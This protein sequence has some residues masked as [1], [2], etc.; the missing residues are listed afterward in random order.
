MAGFSGNNDIDIDRLTHMLEENRDLINDITSKES[1][2]VGAAQIP[3]LLLDIITPMENGSE[4]ENVENS[5][6]DAEIAETSAE[7]AGPSSKVTTPQEIVHNLPKVWKVLVELLSH[8]KLKP[9]EIEVGF[10][11]C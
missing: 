3:K 6:L 5:M 2:K 10:Y 8:Q 4:S 9:V 7:I 11:H 1:C